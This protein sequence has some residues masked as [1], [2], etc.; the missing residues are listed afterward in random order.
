MTG[1]HVWRIEGFDGTELIFG[2]DIPSHLLS[3]NQV[4]E[5]FRRL[6]SQHLSEE[7]VVGASLN[8]KANRTTAIGCSA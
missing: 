5:L 4:E 1:K 3:N 2:T 8:R 6:V 7:E